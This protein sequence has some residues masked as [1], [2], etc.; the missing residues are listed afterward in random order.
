MNLIQNR[1]L[2]D[3]EN[4]LMDTKGEMQEGGINQEL[5][6]NVHTPLYIKYITNKDLLHSTGNSNQYSGITY[7]RKETENELIYMYN[8]ITLL[9]A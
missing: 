1:K 4:E 3:P 6:I 8:S 9:Y 7:M 2:T 5:G